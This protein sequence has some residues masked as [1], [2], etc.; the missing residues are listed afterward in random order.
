M[1]TLKK[2]LLSSVPK[3]ILKM[4]AFALTSELDHFDI[5]T[6]FENFVKETQQKLLSMPDIQTNEE[7]A[8]L[9]CDLSSF[10]SINF[11]AA[12]PSSSTIAAKEPYPVLQEVAET[13]LTDELSNQ[14][15][16]DMGNAIF[17]DAKLSPVKEGAF[18][19][20]CY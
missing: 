2:I 14:V 11:E 5:E 4:A 1:H 8:P 13:V 20:R 19:S 18:V 15:V 7:A 9:T 6:S 3:L 10:M 17:G 16:K 12:E